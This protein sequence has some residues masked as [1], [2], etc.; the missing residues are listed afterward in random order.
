MLSAGANFHPI[1]IAVG[2]FNGDG[3]LDIAVANHGT[4]H[5]DMMLGNENGEF[6]MQTSYEIDFDSPPIV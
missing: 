4:K 5:V 3:V 1:S 2:D 6:A